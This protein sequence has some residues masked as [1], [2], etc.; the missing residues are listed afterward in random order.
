M[1]ITQKELARRIRAA[2]EACGLTQAKV[3]EH[4]GISRPTVVQIEQGKR[5]VSSLELSRLAYLFGRDLR[6]FLQDSFQEKNLLSALFRAEPGVLDRP[7]VAEALRA[8]MALGR[9]VRNLEELLGIERIQRVPAS[10]SLPSPETKGEAVQQGIKLA[11]DERNRLGLPTAPLPD[12]AELLAN[13]G[14]HTAV[15]DLPEDVSGLT[16]ND[17]RKGLF[18]FVNRKHHLLRR[19]FSFA[20]EYAHILADRSRFGVV[21]RLSQRENLVEV[22]ANA[23]AAN[24]LM[25]EEGVRRFLAQ[26]GKIGRTR[27]IYQVFDTSG[28]MKVEDRMAPGSQAIQLHDV[29]QLAEF[30]RVSLPSCIYRLHD[31]RLITE[32]ES[33][34][35][36]ALHQKGAGKLVAKLLG[37][38][39]PRHR[40]ERNWFRNRL[41]GL[42]LE[43]FRREKISRGK[44]IAFAS[45]V[46][47]DREQVAQLLERIGSPYQGGRW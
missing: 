45:M 36:E 16:L 46:G 28:S 3:A 37:F 4:L 23:F 5:S 38:P 43:A 30:F 25:P 26:L 24:F 42:A 13:Q 22:R 31:L 29:V 18:V 10:Y 1:S 33:A 14:I 41:L 8:C 47:L 7:H 17:P 9:E 39:Q 32:K 11:M 35:L 19:R 2:R 15:L 21:S 27:P 6:D 40:K 44:L 20:H 34:D 12:L